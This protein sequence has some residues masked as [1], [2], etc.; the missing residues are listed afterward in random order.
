MKNKRII[1]PILL[2]VLAGGLW[3]S[4]VFSSKTVE[5]TSEKSIPE[6]VK[7]DSHS[8]Q[9][10]VPIVEEGS[11]NEITKLIDGVYTYPLYCSNGSLLFSDS[12]NNQ[13]LYQKDVNSKPEVLLEK[14]SFGNNIAWSKNCGFVYFKVKTPDY[15]I[16]F[17]SIN[18]ITKEVKTLDNYPPLTE[19][20]SIAVSDTIYFIDKKTLEVKGQYN[21]DVWN[22]SDSNKKGNYYN[23][24]IS[25][26]NKYLAVHYNTDVLLFSTNGE[27][28]RNLGAGTATDWSPDSD[29]LIGFLEKSSDGHSTNNSEIVKYDITKDTP[30]QLTSTINAVETWPTFKSRNTIVYA[31]E[32]NKGLFLLS[33]NN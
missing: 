27:F 23:I 31:D 10:H 6:V 12:K 17:K 20:K 11:P 9:I 18:V 15:K 4:G 22:I 24:L 16:V 3:A 30:E 7:K 21:D 26:N 32:L 25:P 8:K 33:I 1:I 14:N 19:L 29:F 2:F 5:N 28:I 13:L